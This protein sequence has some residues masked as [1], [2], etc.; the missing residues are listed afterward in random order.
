MNSNKAVLYNLERKSINNKFE[1]IFIKPFMKKIYL[2]AIFSFF[3]IITKTN[4]QIGI[5]TPTPD[6]S[7]MLDVK[8]PNKGLL[9][10]RVTLIGTN[11]VTT[12][13]SPATSLLVYNTTAA[14]SGGT[15]VTTGYYYWNGTAW[16]QFATGSSSGSSNAWLLTGNAGTVDSTNFIGTIDNVPFNI[17]VNNKKAGRIDQN[18][19]NTF[20][21][22][23]TGNANTTGNNN[24]A[25]GYAGLQSNTTGNFN[26]ANGVNA[27]YFNTTGSSNTSNGALS[28][29]S[30][31]TGGNN[32]AN[33]V[34][35]LYKNTTGN[36]NTANG[37]S[38]LYKN[39]TGGFNTANGFQSLYS[40]A[41]GSNNTA[42]GF[43]ALSSNS[44]GDYN[45]ANGYGTL[46]S[47]TSGFNN[48]A[49][50]AGADVGSS[51]LSNAT[52]IGANSVVNASDKVRIGSTAVTVIEGQ[53]AYSFPSDKRFKYNIKDNVPGLEFIK[54]LTPVTYY[55]D[56]KKLD[57][58]S[59]TGILNNSFIHA[60]SYDGEKQLHTG[61]LAQDVEKIAKDLGYEFDGVHA[62][63]N[64]KDHYSLA[65]SQFIMPLVKGMQ[66]QQVIIETLQKQN[67]E[68][69]KRVEKIE[70]KI[71]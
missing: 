69:I 63:A 23:Q 46:S 28:L 57:E 40:N 26:T 55:F 30:N 43:N 37:V 29:Y 62:P 19:L 70:S 12:I 58:Y 15:A 7:A 14:G 10:P 45:T 11:D 60:A 49:L 4:A 1:L 66:E 16:I 39:I 3:I 52:A 44:I 67:A 34:T 8:N 51:N 25:N 20:W 48:T 21:G 54:I 22:Y 6:N 9:V 59:K 31:T 42:N 65:Y 61:F 50:G 68:L 71:K 56:E 18:L 13:P 17:R 35:A 41:T 38:A 2:L 24:T 27:L 36:F 33:G 47:N 5:G 64:G 53:V 32:T